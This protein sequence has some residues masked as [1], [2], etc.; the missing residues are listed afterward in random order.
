MLFW[1]FRLLHLVA[2]VSIWFIDVSVVILHIKSW[3]LH[4]LIYEIINFNPSQTTT[5]YARPSP[6]WISTSSTTM[7]EEVLWHRLTSTSSTTTPTWEWT[8]FNCS[9]ISSATSISIGLWVLCIVLYLQWLTH[10]RLYGTANAVLHCTKLF[11]HVPMLH[12]CLW[13]CNDW[14]CIWR[15]YVWQWWW[16][17]GE[18]A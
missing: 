2:I 11:K 7:W 14:F 12:L 1:R 8:S 18:C 6:G 5:A 13:G 15:N 10:F 9:P 17:N 3:H 16:W 4:H